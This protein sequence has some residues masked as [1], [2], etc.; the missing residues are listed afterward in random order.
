MNWFKIADKIEQLNLSAEGLAEIEVSGKKICIS[1]KNDSIQA[2]AAKCP[3]AGGIMANGYVDA[4]GN[5][6]CP[7]HRYCFS[8]QNGRNTSGEG[9]FL[10][11][12]PV[13]TRP[14]G[15]FVGIK[16]NNLFNW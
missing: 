7:L 9:Y 1:V 14:E 4:L 8:L 12:Y 16:E 11:V 5:I 13:E 10:K 3:H 6:V 15:I 2:C